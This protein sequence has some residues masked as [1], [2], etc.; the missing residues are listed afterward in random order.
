MFKLSYVHK[1]RGNIINNLR[2]DFMQRRVEQGGKR[3]ICHWWIKSGAYAPDEIRISMFLSL[4][5]RNIAQ[6]YLCIGEPIIFSPTVE[7]QKAL[8]FDVLFHYF[9]TNFNYFKHLSNC[10]HPGHSLKF[11]LQKL[12]YFVRKIIHVIY[13]TQ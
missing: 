1:W 2:H 4:F 7:T 10:L 12:P 13:H 5:L 8:R 9:V 3:G 11:I 6:N